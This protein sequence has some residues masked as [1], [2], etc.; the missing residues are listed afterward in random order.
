MHI[1]E[2][3]SQYTNSM[4]K[5]NEIKTASPD[6]LAL[7]AN[8]YNNQSKQE[9]QQPSKP[10]PNVFEMSK[11]FGGSQMTQST[12]LN[13]GS[14]FGGATQTNNPFA[15][16]Q[17]TTVQPTSSFTF[18][19]DQQAP[20]QSIFG[21]SQQ[22]Q[23]LAP[24]SSIFGAS[25]PSMGGSQMA[26]NQTS[27]F[28]EK[29]PSN[30]AVFG[31]AAQPP[32]APT[33]IFGGAVQTPSAPTGIFGSAQQATTTAAPIFG[34]AAQQ[35]PSNSIFGGG[36]LQQQTSVPSGL[37]ASVPPATQN[38]PFSNPSVF[39]SFQSQAMGQPAPSFFTQANAPLQNPQQPL[40]NPFAAVQSAP[41]QTNSGSIFQTQSQFGVPTQAAFGDNPFVT[42]P[43]PIDE[44]AYSKIEDLTAEELKAFEADSFQ[45][46][47]IPL[48]PPP[49]SLCN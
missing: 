35:P 41:V 3:V 40:Q 18:S 20:Q 13:A 7:V 2:L 23:P 48:K 17:T 1:N 37:F 16:S 33:G 42:K 34:I 12:G 22:Q 15:S 21:S 36:A 29:Q 6:I 14:I 32:S 19:L 45:L 11:V 30:F 5:L 9:S 38:Q 27:I 44:S 31:G 47:H 46:G 26:T 8:I 25:Q 4:A 24:Q 10:Q 49:R 39:S 28:G 43:A